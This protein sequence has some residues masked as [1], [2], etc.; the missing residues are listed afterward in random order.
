M[1]QHRSAGFEVA[2]DDEAIELFFERGLTDGLPVVPPTEQRVARMMASMRRLGADDVIGE[3]APNYRPATV[4]RIAVNAVMAG[5]RP[6]YFPVVVAGIRA[7]CRPQFNLHGLQA[8]TH[9]AAPLF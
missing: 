1:A 9:F 3:I 5:C 2:G 8:T 4:Q 7:M 6:D